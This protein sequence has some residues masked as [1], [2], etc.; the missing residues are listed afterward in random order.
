LIKL[1]QVVYGYPGRPVLRGL[2]LRVAAGEVVGLLGRNGAGKTTT[3]EIVMG[4][5]RAHGG[6]CRVTGAQVSSDPLAARRSIGFVAESPTALTMLTAHDH[7]RFVARVR[8]FA[9]RESAERIERV[10]ALVDLAGHGDELVDHY[11]LGMRQR[12]GLA[13]ALLPDPAV[14]LLDEPTNGL[15]P[16]GADDLI[17][18]L[19][20]RADAGVAVL[21]SSHRLDVV[22]RVCDRVLFL[23]G[24][25][26][27]DEARPAE[28][29]TGARDLAHRFMALDHPDDTAC[30]A[31]T[32]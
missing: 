10:L 7:L 11:S 9:S 19:R 5:R 26:I 28:S 30:D 12:L 29:T 25:V 1:E 8:G 2:D 3:L 24:G 18:I 23:A 16:A 27:A 17:T 22:D 20:A 15:D 31:V 4:L 21:L 32:S 14:L 6:S 13:M